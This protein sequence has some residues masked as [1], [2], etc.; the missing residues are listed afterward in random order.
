MNP[1]KPRTAF[2]TLEDENERIT[3][4]TAELFASLLDSRDHPGFLTNAN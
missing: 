1:T 3:R 2:A 4:A